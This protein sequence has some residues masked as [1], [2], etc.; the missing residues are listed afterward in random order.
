MVYMSRYELIIT[1]GGVDADL[2]AGV[3][4]TIE[5]IPPEVFD[6]NGILVA[7]G[8]SAVPGDRVIN[9]IE[10]EDTLSG[11]GRIHHYD[12]GFPG[13]DSWWY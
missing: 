5:P 12:R 7:T 9:P 11:V 3:A 10:E 8:W 1:G 6:T 13:C 4:W 2:L